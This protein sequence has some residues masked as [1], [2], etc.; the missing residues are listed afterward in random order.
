MP[1]A[2]NPVQVNPLLKSILYAGIFQNLY[3]MSFLMSGLYPRI[4]EHMQIQENVAYFEMKRKSKNT[5]TKMT[6]M[7]Q[8]VDKGLKLTIINMFKVGR[9]TT[10]MLERQKTNDKFLFR[11]KIVFCRGIEIVKKK[12]N[13]GVQKYSI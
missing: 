8:L 13:S 5:D 7:L 9:E 2:H 6:Q 4:T 3:S 10:C 1:F 12:Q 11:N